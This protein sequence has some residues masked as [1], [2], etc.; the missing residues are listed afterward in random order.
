MSSSE[1]LPGS[2][3]RSSR[4]R[5]VSLPA[6]CCRR[7]R[8]GPPMPAMRSL[9]WRRSS[10][11]SDTTYTSQKRERGKAGTRYSALCPSQKLRPRIL[12]VE[13]SCSRDPALRPEPATSA[14]GFPRSR[15]LRFQ[16]VPRPQRPDRENPVLE[17]QLAARIALHEQRVCAEIL[18]GRFGNLIAIA[19]ANVHRDSRGDELAQVFIFH[20][21]PLP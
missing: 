5:A 19:A 20:R 8:S 7:T 12:R 3:S 2:S 1:K 6:S 9:R 13:F 11:R 10:M 4:S 21:T 16:L 18:Y 17:D 14:W 15:S